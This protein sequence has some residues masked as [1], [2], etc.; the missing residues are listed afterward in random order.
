MSIR[1]VKNLDAPLPPYTEEITVFPVAVVPFAL[2]A[3]ES[4]ALPSCWLP[5]YRI[6]GPQLIR[7][8]QVALLGGFMEELIRELRALR[9]I[10]PEYV[11]VPV[12]EQEPYMFYSITDVRNELVLSNERIEEIR[13]DVDDIRTKVEQQGTDIADIETAMGDANTILTL[14]SSLL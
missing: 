8:L 9:G 2:A 1:F 12:E 3:L 7:M 5:Q 13:L 10:K 4:R 6:V 14:I 11:N